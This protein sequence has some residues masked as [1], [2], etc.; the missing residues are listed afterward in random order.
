V[1]EGESGGM[2][3]HGAEEMGKPAA[4][5]HHRKLRIDKLIIIKINLQTTI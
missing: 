3:Q 2:W 1:K 5:R 4:E